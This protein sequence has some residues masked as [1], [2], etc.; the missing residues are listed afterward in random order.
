MIKFA[1]TI[2]SLPVLILFAC[3][4]NKVS[5]TQGLKASMACTPTPRARAVAGST[6]EIKTQPFS[7]EGM[8]WIPGGSFLMG[9]VDE[10]AKPDEQPQHLV[11]LD[12]FWMDETEVTNAQF[13]KFVES[14][15]YITTAEKDVD[16]EEL[17]KQLPGNTPRPA[18]S[19][20]KA[21][22]L[23]FTPPS[24]P[25]GLHDASQWWTWKKGANWKHPQGPG[26][27]IT[28]KDDHPVVHISWDDAQAYCKWAG[29]RLPTEAEWEYAA[30]GGQDA[31]LYP[32]GN[33]DV[34]QG[35]PKANTWQG[36]FPSANTNQ[37]GFYKS[38]PVKTFAPNPYGL[39]DMAGNVWEWCSDWY[40]ANH[41]SKQKNPIPFNPLGPERSNDPMEPGMPKKIIRGGSF[42]CHASYCRGYRLTSR[43]KA[44]PDTGLE[45][46]GFRA[47]RNR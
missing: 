32:W 35:K 21:S 5:T 26:S 28:G 6:G 17:K 3:S 7:N 10:L 1:L 18:D 22:S 39:Y 38:S 8:K 47:V 15:G 30:R 46:T 45:H 19:L 31:Q 2:F 25:V 27:D 37:D 12:G 9:A 41:Y 11:K 40:D 23:V 13:R 24:H 29:K 20:L 4:N 33:E 42:M 36:S 14:T 43:M 44:S 16:W 34:E